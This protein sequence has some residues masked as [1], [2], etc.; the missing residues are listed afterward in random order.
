M[1]EALP[2]YTINVESN[3]TAM[4]TVTGGGTY[5]Q[6]AT[7]TITATP[8]GS[9]VFLKWMRDGSQVSTNASYTFVVNESATYTAVFGEPAV[10]YYTITTDV[11][12]AGAG[13]VD[14]GD[15]YASG[16]T[17]APN[18]GWQFSKWSDNNTDNPHSITVTGNANYTAYFTRTTHTLTVNASP[19]E[20]GTVTG[21]G[22]YEYGETVGLNATPNEGYEFLNWNDGITTA[23][24]TVMVTQDATYTAYFIDTTTTVYTVTVIPADATMGSVTGG[25]TFPE[26]TTISI[27]AVPFGINVFSHWSDGS[28]SNPRTITV[29]EDITYIAYFETPTLYTITVTSQNPEMGS[30]NGGGSFPMGAE[31]TIQANPFG[32]YYF[33]GWTDNNYDN[34][35]TITVSGDATYTAR[36]SAQQ[37]QTYM[38]TV[39]CNP[40]QGDVIGTGTY[41]PGTVVNVEAIP[42]EG[43]AFDRWNDGV[44]D[45]PRTV[46][47][48]S[49]LT[50][51][52]FF[53]G[54]GVDENGE[55]VLNVYPNPAKESIRIE[56]LE[57]NAEVLFY[58]TLGM[59]VKQVNAT[60]DQEINVSDLASGLYL[61]RSGRQTL[62]F[63]KE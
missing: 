36:F 5:T 22:T 9:Y 49:N 56:G 46:T 13:T 19:A 37:T 39:T 52:A 17:A 12:P 40:S 59:L 29:T 31:V 8:S 10:T 47:V 53:K 43:F 30:V 55:T 41:S 45:N 28:T 2:E 21:G 4:G 44:T 34:P 60:A 54:T 35:R 14:G 61:V 7:C 42:Y 63:V 38:L 48:N 50:L 11:N 33:D 51:V 16:A 32:G 26:G 57:P 3:N 15:T 20:G 23:Y 58:N 27:E 18:Q 24:R 25:G 62:R 6:G 1:T